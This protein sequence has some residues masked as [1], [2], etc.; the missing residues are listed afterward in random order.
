MC[1]LEVLTHSISKFGNG[2]FC[3]FHSKA[4]EAACARQELVLQPRLPEGCPEVRDLHL[5]VQLSLNGIFIW[6]VSGMKPAAASWGPTARQIWAQYEGKDFPR[7]L[8]ECRMGCLIRSSASCPWKF[9]RK[10]KFPLS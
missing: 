5:S 1:P 2:R 3:S 9:P 10:A 8:S 7:K 6:R 4:L